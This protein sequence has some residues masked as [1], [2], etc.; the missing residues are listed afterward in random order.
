MLKIH[1]SSRIYSCRVSDLYL[2]VHVQSHCRLCMGIVQND[3]KLWC[4]YTILY[5]FIK[6]P[7]A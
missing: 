7:I 3:T 1:V 5:R 2:V 6:R 4:L